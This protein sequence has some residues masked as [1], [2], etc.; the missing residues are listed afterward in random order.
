M[1]R[2]QHVVEGAGLARAVGAA[3]RVPGSG[4]ARGAP[5]QRHTQ[6]CWGRGGLLPKRGPL[7]PLLVRQRPAVLYR[8]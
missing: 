2:K 6:F 7:L 3:K 4:A 8:G 1:R 5:L